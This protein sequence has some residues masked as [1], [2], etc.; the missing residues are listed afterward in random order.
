MST[1][2]I[3]PAGVYFLEDVCRL[4]RIPRRNLERLRTHGAFPIPELPRLDKR[5]RWSG[6]EILKFLEGQQRL[7]VRGW[8]KSA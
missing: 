1:P 5:P 8:K 4:L 7:S 2:T 3:D 6:A